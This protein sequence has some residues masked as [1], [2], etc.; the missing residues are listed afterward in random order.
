MLKLFLDANVLF[1]AAYSENGGSAYVFQLAKRKLINIVSSK[2]AF[3]EA[4]RNLIAKG[5]KDVMIRFYTNVALLGD[6]YEDE[7]IELEINSEMQN[8]INVKDLP[9]LLSAIKNKSDYLLTLDRKHFFT[10]QII[11][12][13]KPIILCTPKDYLQ[14]F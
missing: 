3:I 8:L 12:F 11:D 2:Y 1:T 14:S 10:K 9:I 7:D 5:S 13:I 6:L 4:E